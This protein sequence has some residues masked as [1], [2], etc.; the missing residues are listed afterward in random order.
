MESLGLEM[1]LHDGTVVFLP[2]A[3]RKLIRSMSLAVTAY[4]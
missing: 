2:E 3:P 4:C 1:R